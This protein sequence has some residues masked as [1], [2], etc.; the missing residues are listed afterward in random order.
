MDLVEALTALDSEKDDHWTAQ[1]LPRIEVLRDMTGL[2]DLTRSMV[3]QLAPDYARTHRWD[4]SEGDDTDDSPPVQDDDPGDQSPQTPAGGG[5][6]RDSEAAA[7]HDGH[8]EATKALL[9]G[10][11][12]LN[13]E[14][15]DLRSEKIR[16]DK[17]IVAKEG[18]LQVLEMAREAALP[19]MTQAQVVKEYHKT[20]L[21][22]RQRASDQRRAAAEAVG[23]KSMPQS[24]VGMSQLD[25]NMS[26]RRKGQRARSTPSEVRR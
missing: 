5:N 1:G 2:D 18:E 25:K 26:G 21:Q 23:L 22:Q 15:N 24:R 6:A 8:D 14:C 19:R 20:Q 3:D 4:L 17:A 9:E 7:A 11:D 12:R 16:I 13:Q 10:I